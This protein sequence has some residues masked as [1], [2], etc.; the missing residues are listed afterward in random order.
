MRSKKVGWVCNIWDECEG[1]KHP[2]DKWLALDLQMLVMDCCSKLLPQLTRCQLLIQN[3][4]YE[5]M[6]DKH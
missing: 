1:G 5:G 2:V 3:Q 6:W 4:K